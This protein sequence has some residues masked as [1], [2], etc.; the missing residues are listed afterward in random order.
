MHLINQIFNKIFRVIFIPL[1]V[2]GPESALIAFSIVTGMLILILFKKTSNQNAIQYEKKHIWAH[3][4]ELRLYQDNIIIILNAIGQI[5]LHNLLYL[6]HVLRPLILLTPFMTIVL[7]QL[8]IYYEFNP[9]SIDDSFLIAVRVADNI[10]LQSVSL[11]TPASV[12]VET[13]SVRQLDNK[14][15]IWRLCAKQQGIWT[16]ILRYQDQIVKKSINVESLEQPLSYGRFTGKPLKSLFYSAEPLLLKECFIREVYI[17]YPKQRLSIL[18]MQ[19]NWL[20][21][22][23]VVSLVTVFALKGI[24]GVKL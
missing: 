5:L 14:K 18:G 2:F 23:G 8:Y 20:V 19:T 4:L 6:K 7:V 11:E 9:V 17:D 3:I 10:K 16:L 15:I 24:M 13:P 21:V 12:V 22:F 1:S